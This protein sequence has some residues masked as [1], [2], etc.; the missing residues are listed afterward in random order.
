M[1]FWHID[2]SSTLCH[3]VQ[4]QKGSRYVPVY[5][6]Q[7]TSYFFMA[8]SKVRYQLI[9]TFKSGILTH[10]IQM[11]TYQDEGSHHKDMTVSQLS[12]LY[13]GNLNTL[14]DGIYIETTHWNWNVIS[15][16]RK[17]SCP[18]EHTMLIHW[19]YVFCI[20]PLILAAFI[21]K[22]GFSLQRLSYF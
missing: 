4:H 18:S 17:Q 7:G 16:P 1:F 6:L 13:T 22:D 5:V 2:K 8:S 10:N 20:K 3:L 14:K 9:K 21:T 15:I 11:L 19:S 12:N